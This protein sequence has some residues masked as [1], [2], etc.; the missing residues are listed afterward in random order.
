VGDWT[1]LD[2]S[3]ELHLDSREGVVGMRVSTAGLG[4]QMSRR[5]VFDAV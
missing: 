2:S 1:D 5:C 4:L 3:P